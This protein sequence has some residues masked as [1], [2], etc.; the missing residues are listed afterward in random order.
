VTAINTECFVSFC[1][2]NYAN[3]FFDN[4]ESQNLFLSS[5]QLNSF[6][7]NTNLVLKQLDKF[8]DLIYNISFIKILNKFKLKRHCLSEPLWNK[9]SWYNNSINE[10][11]IVNLSKN[12]FCLKL[13]LL[14]DN[15]KETKVV[16][17]CE[18]SKTKICQI[19][20]NICFIL[21]YIYGTVL[22]HRVF[23]SQDKLNNK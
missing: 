16:C 12:M 15:I 20:I 17:V 22:I 18:T 6:T 23:F 14:N 2:S 10:E 5:V 21:K 1:T 11:I 8:N 4:W 3:T 13:S 7:F 9:N 19:K